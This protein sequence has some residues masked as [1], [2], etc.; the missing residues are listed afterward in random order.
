M[1]RMTPCPRA[2]R[3]CS[4]P[5]KSRRSGATSRKSHCTWPSRTASSRPNPLRVARGWVRREPLFDR[6]GGPAAGGVVLVCA[7]AG[8]GKT[9][10]L[11]FV[12]RGSRAARSR[13][14]GLRRARRGGRAAVLAVGDRGAG[15]GRPRG[16]AGGPGAELPRRGGGRSAAGGPRIARAAGRPRHRR[17]P[18]ARVRRSPALARGLPRP[19]SSRAAAWCW[20]RAR[21]RSSVCIACAW[22]AS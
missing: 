7:P 8:S 13:R 11:A 22:R 12:G 3:V 14:L 17:P 16:G 15:R 2:R 1:F 5:S 18:R 21:T 19:P 9:V 10:L 4:A 20:P 6:I